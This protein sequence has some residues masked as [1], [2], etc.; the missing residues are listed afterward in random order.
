MG[1]HYREVI[2]YFFFFCLVQCVRMLLDQSRRL[3]LLSL[4]NIWLLPPSICGKNIRPTD[5][6]IYIDG[7]KYRFSLLLSRPIYFWDLPTL[8]TQV[9]EFVFVTKY[10]CCVC[11]TTPTK[12]EA[13]M[14]NLLLSSTSSLFQLPWFLLPQ[15][16]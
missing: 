4:P 2:L 12:R 14:R 3:S 6:L 8:N 7:S 16:H 10:V 13:F 5:H 11:Y 15:R 1:V 9:W